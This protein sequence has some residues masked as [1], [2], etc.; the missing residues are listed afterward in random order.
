MT[1]K[2]KQCRHGVFTY[3]TQDYYIGGALDVTGE[4]SP[5]ELTKLQLLVPPSGRA[6]L[7][8]ANIGTLA[9]PLAKHLRT[10]LLL[11]FEPQP[12]THVLLT[13]NF[14]QNGL[15]RH[16]AS[17]LALGDRCGKALMTRID[18]DAPSYNSGSAALLD[19]GVV[20]SGQTFR[21]HTVEVD[22]VTIDSLALEYLDLIHA[23]V[24]GSELAVIRGAVKTIARHRPFLYV[25]NNHKIH[26]AALIR[27]IRDLGYAC[28]W[29]LPALY[30]PDP[31][32]GPLVSAN[33]LCCPNNLYL[34]DPSILDDTWEVLSENETCDQAYQRIPGRVVKKVST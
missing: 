17:E 1:R 5:A 31:A 8:G 13:L 22:M 18:Y 26:S 27:T 20:I 7:V 2:T 28:Y 11:A 24:E 3:Y 4:N 29:H 21:D 9:V 30:N 25:E 10:G 32:G 16:V 33:M 23:D 34:R 12:A 6:L 14:D 15:H 19:D